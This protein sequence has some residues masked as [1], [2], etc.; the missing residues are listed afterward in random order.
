MVQTSTRT[1]KVVRFLPLAV[2]LFAVLALVACIAPEGPFLL[3]VRDDA[4]QGEELIAEEG[5]AIEVSE[6]ESVRVEGSAAEVTEGEVAAE[7]LAL[8]QV[9]VRASYLLGLAVVDS[10]GD[11]VGEIEDLVVD[12]QSGQILYVLLDRSELLGLMDDVRPLPLSTLDWTPDLQM[13]L[14]I[15]TDRLDLIPQ[16][17]DEWPDAFEDGWDS[18]VSNF[19]HENDI[20]VNSEGE[21]IPARI[22]SLIGIHAGG[23]GEDLAIAEDF[24]IDIS[25]ERSEY[26]ALFSANGFYDPNLVLIVPVSV[27]ELEIEVV[28]SGPAYGLALLAVDS[29]TLEAAPTMAR[30][31][32]LSVDLVSSEFADELN[33][34]WEGA[35]EQE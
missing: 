21:A 5:D 33:T 2:C 22:R 26:V 28:D 9:L 19:W 11:K 32:F 23:L 3:D 14:N 18:A 8:D 4:L 12:I 24:L 29:E 34:F 17:D 31:L 30:D 7:D 16:V 25:R 6:V 15:P 10:L 1:K 35:I 27:T 13:R 20:Q